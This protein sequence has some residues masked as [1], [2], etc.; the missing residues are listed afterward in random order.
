METQY[1]LTVINTMPSTY[2][3]IHNFIYKAKQE[4]LSGDYN[5]LDIEIQLKA[6]EEVIK[7][8]RADGDIKT[9]VIAEAEKH[10]KSFEYRG[11]KLSIREGGVKYDYASTGDS[12]WAM[13][14]AEAKGIA[15]QKKAREE[16][17]KHLPP[18][19]VAD[20]NTGE[21]I[22]PPAKTSSTTIAVTLK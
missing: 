5:P 16:F 17:L 13:L 18:E 12:T 14:D 22:T 2:D 10:G 15:E 9:A 19:G 8:L 20:A 21:F 4:L 1:A 6:M 11:C 3:E 7:Q